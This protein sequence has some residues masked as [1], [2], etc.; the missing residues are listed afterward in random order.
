LGC[1]DN[2]GGSL[3]YA[4]IKEKQTL[5][6]VPHF[7]AFPVKGTSGECPPIFYSIK[8]LNPMS[9]GALNGPHLLENF[10]KSR[11]TYVVYVLPELLI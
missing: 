4:G 8:V 7:I 1:E 3:L 6:V 2:N 5:P 11:S 9:E 10:N